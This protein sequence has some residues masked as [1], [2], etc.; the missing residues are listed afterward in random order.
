MLSEGGVHTVRSH[1]IPEDPKDDGP[2][3]P[4]EFVF[5]LANGVGIDIARISR[6]GGGITLEPWN[7]ITLGEGGA[8]DTYIQNDPIYAPHL[9]VPRGRVRDGLLRLRRDRPARD[10]D[11]S[12]SGT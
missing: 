1:V 8:H 5:S 10:P 3:D 7:F 6:S 4:G 9:P 11:R 2:R 12:P